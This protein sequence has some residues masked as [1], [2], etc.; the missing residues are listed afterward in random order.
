MTSW[1]L[2]AQVGP[3]T[4]TVDD[5][6]TASLAA[7]LAGTPMLLDPLQL[8]AQVTDPDGVWPP[9]RDSDQA[10]VQLFAAKAADLG[11]AIGST[12]TLDLFIPSTASGDPWW[13]FTGT[14]AEAT[15]RPHDWTD[16]ATNNQ[17]RGVLCQ[18]QAADRLAALR[19]LYAGDYDYPAEALVDRI[20]RIAADAGLVLTIDQLAFE[21]PSNGYN[22]SA[23]TSTDGSGPLTLP[24]RQASSTSLVDL[25]QDTLRQWPAIYPASFAATGYCRMELAYYH[26]DAGLHV[27]PVPSDVQVASGPLVLSPGSWRVVASPTASTYVIDGAAVDYDATFALT[28]GQGTT[29]V[30]VTGTFG[31][32]DGKVVSTLPNADHIVTVSMATEL[33][34]KAEA[35]ALAAMYLPPSDNLGTWSPDKLTWDLELQAADLEAGLPCPQLRQLVL[36]APVLATWNPNDREWLV[37]QVAALELAIQDGDLAVDLELSAPVFSG[38]GVADAIAF[39]DPALT[40]PTGPRVDQLYTRDTIDDYR[41]V[42]GS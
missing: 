14:V 7:V 17:L 26:L 30:E 37:G 5:T 13:S 38:D 36:V 29:R 2:E 3:H 23:V 27:S 32:V 10:T 9:A 40:A 31:G 33:A 28:K 24:A 34:T 6:S 20:T 42:R 21:N 25:L 35:R 16:D 4:Y 39:N 18:V 12:V 22:T 8:V 11:L 41:L 1:R 15:T 19:E